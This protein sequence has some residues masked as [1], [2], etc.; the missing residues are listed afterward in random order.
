MAGW[1]PHMQPSLEAHVTMKYER[2]P[3]QTIEQKK[4]TRYLF[5]LCGS[6]QLGIVTSKMMLRGRATALA[7]GDSSSSSSS[8]SFLSSSSG[9]L[10][11][12][13]SPT[14]LDTA[15]MMGWLKAMN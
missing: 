4:V 7:I 3:I 10:K 12:P 8:S 9:S 14:H 2:T 13:S 15:S 1:M 6:E 5:L 11:P